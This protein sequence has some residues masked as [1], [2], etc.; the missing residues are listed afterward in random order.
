[1][2][3]VTGAIIGGAAL[4]AGAGYLGSKKQAGAARDAANLSMDQFNTIN[5][6][7]QPYMNTGYGALGK[8]NTL[9]GLS[10]RPQPSGGYQMPGQMQIPQMPGGM[11][12]FGNMNPQM[13]SMMG[14]VT[15]D[16]YQPQTSPR[17]T[18]DLKLRQILSLRA[19]HGDRQARAMLGNV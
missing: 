10:P 8:L 12:A 19:L 3:G 14:R 4:S 9:M 17:Q 2:C 15:P 6:Q 7:Q 18:Q 1:M 11:Q 13:A 16:M 5:A